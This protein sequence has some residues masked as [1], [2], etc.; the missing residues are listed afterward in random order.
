MTTVQ[1]IEHAVSHLPL[2]DLNKFRNWFDTFDSDAWDK[3]IE[4][5][6]HSGKLDKLASQAL[7]DLANK[8]CVEL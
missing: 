8:R 6:V 2:P 4:G 7:E 1:E 3:Q 5:D